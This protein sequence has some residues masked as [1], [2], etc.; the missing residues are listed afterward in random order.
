MV[1]NVVESLVYCARHSAF[2][3]S[4]PRAKST[5]V[6][7]QPRNDVRSRA[8]TVEVQSLDNSVGSRQHIHR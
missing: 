7:L 8:A 1:H 3:A 4:W 5:T 2:A 6:D